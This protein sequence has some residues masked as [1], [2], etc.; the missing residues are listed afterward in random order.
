MKFVLAL[1]GLVGASADVCTAAQVLE[2]R[3][4]YADALDAARD[5]SVYP[6]AAKFVQAMRDAAGD[7]SFPC[8]SCFFSYIES[9]YGELT[10]ETGACL[11]QGE[12]AECTAAVEVHDA[13]FEDC[14]AGR[15]SGSGES[16]FTAIAAAAVALFATSNL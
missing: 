13:T 7:P 6:T 2:L 9:M 15:S 3:A 4:A 11:V 14:A 5:V 10:S 12:S 8:S 1:S 16:T